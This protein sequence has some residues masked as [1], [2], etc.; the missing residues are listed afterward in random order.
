MPNYDNAIL[1]Y[2][3][4]EPQFKSN[5]A[6]TQI[7]ARL[8]IYAVRDTASPLPRPSL[9]TGFSWWMAESHLAYWPITGSTYETRDGLFDLIDWTEDGFTS[10]QFGYAIVRDSVASQR[11]SDGRGKVWQSDFVQFASLPLK[12][13]SSPPAIS[14]EYVT[15]T[16]PTPTE[17]SKLYLAIRYPQAS[18]SSDYFKNSAAWYTHFTEGPPVNGQPVSP[19]SF[20]TGDPPIWYGDEKT[21]YVPS[22]TLSASPARVSEGQTSTLTITTPSWMRDLTASDL[23]VIG[24]SLS[25]FTKVT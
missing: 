16:F 4:R 21:W 25:N 20:W 6:G 18:A 11:I 13:N 3:L 8:P 19:S 9:S 2:E 10:V 15:F 14:S 12:G 23:N 1:H 17:P 24:G 5:A 7:T 22:V